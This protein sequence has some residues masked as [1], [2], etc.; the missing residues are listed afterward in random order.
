MAKSGGHSLHTRPCNV[1]KRILRGKAPAGGLAMRP[2]R[3]GLI[4]LRPEFLYYLRPKHTACAHL[5]DLHKVVLAH[6]PE[7]GEPGGKRVYAKSG[8]YTRPYILKTVR[9][10]ITK[11]YI[12]S[13][14]GLLNMIAGYGY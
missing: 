3:H 7:E 9:K 8:S 6:S 12:R 14:S 11:L 1:V 4:K 5:G 10:R 13:S 2:Q